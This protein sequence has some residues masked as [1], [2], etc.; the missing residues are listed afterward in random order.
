VP[1]AQPHALEKTLGSALVERSAELTERWLRKVSARLPV[2][3]NRVFPT[4]ELLDH[5]PRGDRLRRALH[6]RGRHGGG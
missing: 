6:R 1:A 2:D 3:E 4:D 5:V